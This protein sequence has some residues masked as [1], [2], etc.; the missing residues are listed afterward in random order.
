L[1]KQELMAHQ[2]S[3]RGGMLRVRPEGERVALCGQAVTVLRGHLVE[4]QTQPPIYP[5]TT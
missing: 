4:L 3:A 2:A 1:G 5:S